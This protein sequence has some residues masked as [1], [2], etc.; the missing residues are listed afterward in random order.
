MQK[1]LRKYLKV[2][3][4]VEENGALFVT[5]DDD[6]LSKR[7]LQNLISKYGRR[8]GIKNVRCSPHTYRHSMAKFSVQSGADIFTLQSILGHSSMDMVRVYIH[9]FSSDVYENHKKFS[10][11]ERLY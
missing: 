6:R 4:S 1:Q 5:I 2:R 3:G 11:V 9:L 8:A 7:Q 10:P